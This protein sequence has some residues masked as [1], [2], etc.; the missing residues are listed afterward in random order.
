MGI[1]YRIFGVAG[2]QRNSKTLPISALPNPTD[3]QGKQIPTRHLVLLSSDTEKSKGT[4]R[5]GRGR[6]REEEVVE[7]WRTLADHRESVLGKGEQTD[8]L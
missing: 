3:Q 6:G 1:T 2:P 4:G 7:W 5:R 8:L